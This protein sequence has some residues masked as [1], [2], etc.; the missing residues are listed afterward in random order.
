[1]RAQSVITIATPRV[2]LESHHGHGSDSSD[3][4]T[5]FPRLPDCDEN[6]SLLVVMMTMI[7][8]MAKAGHD[9]G[10]VVE[11]DAVRRRVRS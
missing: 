9:A 2:L 6:C 7:M 10:I 8:M 4:C 5:A 11:G 1:M 3:L